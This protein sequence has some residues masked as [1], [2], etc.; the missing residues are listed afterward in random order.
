MLQ[1]DLSGFDCPLPV[2]KTKKFLATIDAGVQ[3]EVITTDPASLFDLQD[4]CIKTGHKLI[5]QT[6]TGPII[7]TIIEHR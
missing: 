7:K 1:L 4:F 2:L 3:L 5:S 6:Q